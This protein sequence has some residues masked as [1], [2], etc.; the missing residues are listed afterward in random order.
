MPF[1]MYRD[2]PAGRPIQVLISRSIE[3]LAARGAHA[4][5][6]HAAGPAIYRENAAGN[7]DPAQ[8]SRFIVIPAPVQLYAPEPRHGSH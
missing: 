8:S 6:A 4:G 7:P 3:S 1:A 5:A 2:I